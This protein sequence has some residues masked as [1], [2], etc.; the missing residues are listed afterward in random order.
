MSYIHKIVL[1]IFLFAFTIDSN[2][3]PAATHATEDAVKLFIFH[4]AL[5]WIARTNPV[6]PVGSELQG[7]KM[8]QEYF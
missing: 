8:E 3:I 2:A 5:K 6:L 1:S 4:F 7:Q